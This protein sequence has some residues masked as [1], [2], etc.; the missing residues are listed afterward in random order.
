MDHGAFGVPRFK[1]AQRRFAFHEFAIGIVLDHGDARPRAQL[2]DA[3][4]V[5][6]GHHAAERIL[7]MRHDHHGLECRMLLQ[8]ELERLDR[9]SRAR[10]R[11]NLQCAQAEA[12]EHLQEAIKARRLDRNRVPRLRDGAQREVDGLGAAM[13]HHDLVGVHGDARSHR[14]ARDHGAQLRIAAIVAGCGEQ[15]GALAQRAHGDL[16]QLLAGKERIGCGDAAQIERVRNLLKA[17][18]E[19]GNRRVDTHELRHERSVLRLVAPFWLACGRQR[20]RARRTHE[21]AFA[22]TRLDQ[23]FAFEH[24]IAFGGRGEA[25]GVLAHERAHRRHALAGA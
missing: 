6:V 13:R 18:D 11:G 8:G 24:T 4:L 25:H 20:I 12:F 16:L 10:A 21:I 9:K 23:R 3:P 2:D 7:Q 14:A 22:R 1:R 15:I 17:G 5:V 19:R